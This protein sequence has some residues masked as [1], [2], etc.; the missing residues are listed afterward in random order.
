[1][2]TWKAQNKYIQ[3]IFFLW[4]NLASNFSRLKVFLFS[5]TLCSLSHSL[6]CS[7]R[8]HTL[9]ILLYSAFLLCALLFLNPHT[10]THFDVFPFHSHN[11]FHTHL[12]HITHTPHALSFHSHTHSLHTHLT[13]SLILYIFS[14]L[15]LHVFFSCSLTR[16][17]LTLYLLST[18]TSH[19]LSSFSCP[20]LLLIL[21]NSKK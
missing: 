8:L 17:L 13:F 2:G 4:Y 1:M 5:L 6:S 7:L 18:F 3:T 14:S 20:S 9:Y 12:A 15:S 19:S 11:T 21:P 16:S 10:P